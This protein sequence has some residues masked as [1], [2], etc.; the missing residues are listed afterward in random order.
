M[1]KRLAQAVVALL[2]TTAATACQPPPAGPVSTVEV[3]ETNVHLGR[4]ADALEALVAKEC[5]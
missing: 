4:I 5:R 3:K 1:R 2:V